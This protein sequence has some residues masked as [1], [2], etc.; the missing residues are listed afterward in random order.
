MKLEHTN[1]TTRATTVLEQDMYNDLVDYANET[2]LYNISTA[3]RQAVT[4]FLKQK[5]SK[6]KRRDLGI[7]R[8]VRK[9]K[10]VPAAPV[11]HKE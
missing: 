1:K 8:N 10:K 11:E 3:L 6:H 4:L 7:S 2:Q 5:T 9:N